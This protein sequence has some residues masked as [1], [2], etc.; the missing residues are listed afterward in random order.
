VADEKKRYGAARSV[1]YAMIIP[2][3][4]LAGP[5]V[6]FV[7]GSW[8][9]ESFQTDPWGKVILSLLGF[10][11]SIKQVLNLIQRSSKSMDD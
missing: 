1:G 8:V 7:L 9:D 4:F 11:A 10:V 3:T 2:M 6:G 5:V